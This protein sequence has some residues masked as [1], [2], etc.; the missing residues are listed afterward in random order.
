M[1]VAFGTSTPTSTTV[2]ATST[3]ISPATNAVITRS[4]S[5]TGSRPCNAAR[6]R[7]AS[8]PSA[9]MGNT[10]ITATGGRW[11]SPSP[12]S[13]GSSSR[14][15]SDSAPPP[16]IRGHTTNAC[17]PVATSSRIRVHVRASHVRPLTRRNNCG[18]DRYPAS[19]QLGQHGRLEVTEHRHRNGPRDRRRGHDE[20]MRWPPSPCPVMRLAARLRSGVAR[21]RPRGPDRR[22]RPPP[23]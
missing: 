14:S 4:R 1:T 3:S 10:S 2:V 13:S 11:P 15:R 9:S 16:P 5:S 22:S 23:G 6:R 20:Q 17:R 21:R 8:G 18:R 12:S 7:P 19:G